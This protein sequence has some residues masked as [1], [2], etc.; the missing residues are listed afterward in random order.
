MAGSSELSGHRNSGLLG[1]RD[2]GLLGRRDSGLL[3]R[4]DECAILDHLLSEAAAGRSGS[5]VLRGEPGVGKTALLGHLAGNVD[6][7][8]VA[9]A[10]GVESEMQLDYGGLHQLCAPMLENLSRLPGPQCEALATVFGLS[11][12]PAPDRF[13]VGLASLSLFAEIAERRPLICLV[14]DA[15]WLDSASTQILTFVCRRLLAERVAVVCAA[16]GVL[17]EGRLYQLIRE[18]GPGRERTLEIAFLAPGAEAY[19]FTFG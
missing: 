3:G 6:G 12:G 14:D 4:R 18:P 2:S 13:L 11:R 1:R 10:A 5:L 15:Q 16:R 9:R 17:R 7:W 19:A 8:F